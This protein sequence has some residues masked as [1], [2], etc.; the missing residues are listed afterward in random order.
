MRRYN[1]SDWV[2]PEVRAL[3]KR[4]QRKRGISSLNKVLTWSFVL[5]GL[6]VGLFSVGFLVPSQHSS[7]VSALYSRPV[8]ALWPKISNL[9][10]QAEWR[11][12]VTR[13]QALANRNDHA[14]WLE[15]GAEGN[16]HQE[17]VVYTP[18]YFIV[19]SFGN[20]HSS[21]TGT[22]KIEIREDVGGTRVVLTETVSTSHPLRRISLRFE[23]E[24]TERMQ[25]YLIDL[26]ASV[27]DEV[28][29]VVH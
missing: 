25:Q 20:L 2:P 28:V 13:M 5:I 18:P 8:E 27:G 16:L 4:M 15:Y 12:D 9:E 7:V 26:A 17:L 22:W 14:V 24:R 23:T 11:T 10:A 29:P 21:L 6:C 3:R 19:T 1:E